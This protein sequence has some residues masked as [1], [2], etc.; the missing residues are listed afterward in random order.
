MTTTGYMTLFLS[1]GHCV[2][3]LIDSQSESETIEMFGET[4]LPLL[5]S[6]SMDMWIS[7]F[8]QCGGSRFVKYKFKITKSTL[9]SR[10]NQLTR[11]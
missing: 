4:K 2:R 1:F 5:N 3:L 7:M 10:F 9:P 8:F 11:P 6:S